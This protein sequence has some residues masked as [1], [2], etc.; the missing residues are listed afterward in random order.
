MSRNV[1]SDDPNDFRRNII[2]DVEIIA[3]NNHLDLALIK[4]DHPDGEQFPTVYVQGADSGFGQ[5]RPG[6]AGVR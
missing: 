2:E 1:V 5:T 4:M 3:V 6:T